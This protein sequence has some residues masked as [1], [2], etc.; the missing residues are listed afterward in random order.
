MEL[1]SSKR[2]PCSWQMELEEPQGRL[3]PK[4][5]HIFCGSF[6]WKTMNGNFT[7]SAKNPGARQ[8][9]PAASGVFSKFE[10]WP[11][12]LGL[13]K[14]NEVFASLCLWQCSK[15]LLFR[16]WF[17]ERVSIRH[18]LLDGLTTHS[19]YFS[20]CDANFSAKGERITVT[21]N[22]CSISS[23]KKTQVH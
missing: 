21:I 16:F 13:Y 7:K 22:W 10:I 6:N 23:E 2:F 5:F 14:K 19:I 11:K 9:F 12:V 20:A 17:T 8:E 3:Q 15:L 1:W 18:L 4:P